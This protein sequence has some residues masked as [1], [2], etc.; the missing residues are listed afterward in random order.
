MQA[1][2]HDAG[3]L[4]GIADGRSVGF[5]RFEVVKFEESKS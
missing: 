1:V 2:L 4:V 5:G 3:V